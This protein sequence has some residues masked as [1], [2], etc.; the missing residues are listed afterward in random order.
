VKLIDKS[1]KEFSKVLASEE[2]APGG[3]STAALGGALGAALL[4]MVASLT[5]GRARYAEHEP[6]MKEALKFANNMRL[7]MLDIIDRDTEAYNA[8]S[9]VFAMPKDTEKQKETR[10]SAM[11][12]ALKACTLTPFELIE[13]TYMALQLADDMAGKYN[14]NAASDFG[15][16]VLNLKAAAQGAWLNVL[17]NLDGIKDEIFSAKYILSGNELMHAITELSDDI[18]AEILRKLLPKM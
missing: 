16:A 3:G 10:S 8:V 15:V 14:I 7:R 5:L 18:Y 13:C 4:C 6:F 17:I 9:A 2:P 1:I 12:E 11:Q